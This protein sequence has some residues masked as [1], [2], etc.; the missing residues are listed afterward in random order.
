MQSCSVNFS[1]NNFFIDC[2]L[3][4]LQYTHSRGNDHVGFFAGG[5]QEVVARATTAGDGEWLFSSAKQTLSLVHRVVV[6]Y[7]HM[8]LVFLATMTDS[9]GINPVN[10]S[11]RLQPLVP[12]LSNIL[13]KLPSVLLKVR[14]CIIE[15]TP[16][17]HAPFIRLTVPSSC[18]VT[19][20]RVWWACGHV[21]H[22]ITT[23][24]TLTRRSTLSVP[25]PQGMSHDSHV[26]SH[27]MIIAI[28]IIAIYIT[29]LRLSLTSDATLREGGFNYVL[30]VYFIYRIVGNFSWGQNIHG[31]CGWTM[32]HEWSDLTCTY[33]YL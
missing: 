28:Y 4:L 32:E 14:S 26:I 3:A 15:A 30:Y 7:L 24:T 12:A 16:I 29:G 25:P 5:P 1:W 22:H 13:N 23:K 33:L 31:F 10:L 9:A 27:V 18:H 8:Q 2:V 19:S 6:C 21:S 20:P 11:N 17:D